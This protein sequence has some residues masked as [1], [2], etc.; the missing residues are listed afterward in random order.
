M[1]IQN[2]NNYDYITF[3]SS[4]AALNNF[5]LS[6]SNFYKEKEITIASINPGGVRTRM[7]GNNAR[8]S[9]DKRSKQLLDIICKLDIKDTVNFLIM[10]VVSYLFK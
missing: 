3:R 4:K 10:M 9:I 5:M 7:G 6:L 8:F 2:H 1:G